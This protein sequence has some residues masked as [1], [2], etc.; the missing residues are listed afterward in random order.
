MISRNSHC[1][2]LPI[3]SEWLAEGRDHAGIV[4]SYRQYRR[5]QLRPLADAVQRLLATLDSED[6]RNSLQTLDSFLM[7]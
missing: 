2:S 4:V 3:F 6:L 7:P 5:D 1:T